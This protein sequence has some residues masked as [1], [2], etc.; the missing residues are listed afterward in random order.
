MTRAISSPS[1][2][3][4][5]AQDRKQEAILEIAA[6]RLINGRPD[7]ATAYTTLINPTRRNTN[8]NMRRGG[9]PKQEPAS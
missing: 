1:T 5:A 7:L 3:K 4:V 8:G 6:V 2:W 9:R